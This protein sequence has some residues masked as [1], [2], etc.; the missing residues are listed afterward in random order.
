MLI[1]GKRFGSK[2]CVL[3]HKRIFPYY[4]LGCLFTLAWWESSKGETII[5][6]DMFRY[7][8]SIHIFP[9]WTNTATTVTTYFGGLRKC[10][11]EKAYLDKYIAAEEDGL[12]DL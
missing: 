5:Y 11:G 6:I 10:M 12:N 4:C 9:D 2:F 7:T 1:W 3:L 8:F